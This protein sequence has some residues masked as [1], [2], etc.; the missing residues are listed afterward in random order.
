MVEQVKGLNGS[1]VL[2]FQWLGR[3]DRSRRVEEA[4][5]GNKKLCSGKDSSHLSADSKRMP[6]PQLHTNLQ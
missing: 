3:R 6:H 4:N 1:D 5:E 2:G